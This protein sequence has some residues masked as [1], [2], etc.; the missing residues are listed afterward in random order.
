MF[1]LFRVKTIVKIN[2]IVQ[3]SNFK[4][5]HLRNVD[6]K[7]FSI[8][9]EIKTSIKKKKKENAEYLMHWIRKGLKPKM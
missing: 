2:H 7:I 6:H 9:Q 4:S 3:K 8:F 1:C 5:S